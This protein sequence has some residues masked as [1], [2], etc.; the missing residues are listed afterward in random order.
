VA[1]TRLSRRLS[2]LVTAVLIGIP[3][4]IFGAVVAPSIVYGDPATPTPTI[5]QVTAKLDDMSKQKEA[6]TEQYNA[7]TAD[8]AAKQKAAASAQKQA[9]LA[10]ASYQKARQELSATVAADY[11]G[12]SFTHAG[13][14]LT[15]QSGQSYLDQLDLLGLMSVH[16]ADLVGQLDVGKAAANK[17]TKVAQAL[18][19]QAK[20][21]VNDVDRQRNDVKKSIAQFKALLDRLNAAQLAAYRAAHT[22]P[23]TQVKTAVAVAHN[24]GTTNNG[25]TNNGNGN[26]NNGNGNTNGGGGGG[27]PTPAPTVHAGSKAQIAVNYA[28]AQVGKAY[29]F[30]GTGPNAYDCSGLT[31]MAWAAAGVSLP[32]LAAAQYNYGTHVSASELEPGDLIFLYQPIGHVEIYIGNGVAVS[33]ADEE[34]GIRYVKVADDMADFTGATRLA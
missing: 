33:A 31:M 19:A 20:A 8:L 29:V 14:L 17:A 12:A 27:T 26:T 22:A 18:V 6:L 23:A 21:K 15:S 9:D 4:A 30:A 16:R 10:V 1:L 2:P 13:A 11:E 7:A 25:T 3:I 28:I 32:H 24:G 34:L 5:A